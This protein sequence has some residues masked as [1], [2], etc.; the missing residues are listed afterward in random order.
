VSVCLFVSVCPK[1]IRPRVENG[2]G[3]V[4]TFHLFGQLDFASDRGEVPII[5]GL[6]KDQFR[7]LN[8]VGF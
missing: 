2:G 3:G 8:G 1:V 6:I 7:G 5:G 4:E